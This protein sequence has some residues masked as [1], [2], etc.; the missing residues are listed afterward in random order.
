MAWTAY[1]P[2]SPG[3]LSRL[4]WWLWLFAG[5]LT[6]IGVLL[7][8]AA[9]SV[10]QHKARILEQRLTR[11]LEERDAKTTQL[12]DLTA[13]AT[14]KASVLEERLTGALTERDAKAAQLEALTAQATKKAIDAERSVADMQPSLRV[15]DVKSVEKDTS[16][17]TTIVLGSAYP[18][19]LGEFYARLT[20]SVPVL[21]AQRA[22]I[23]GPGI[24]AVGRLDPIRVEGATVWTGGSQLLAKNYLRVVVATR[25][26]PTLTEAVLQPAPQKK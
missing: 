21:S 4:E 10:N 12:A 14:K 20:F 16:Y 2:D 3:S 23:G 18:V 25:E 13:Q 7:G 24:L 11:A 19:S 15:L 6:I 17:E 26:R 9:R 8:F 5:S 1:L 22:V